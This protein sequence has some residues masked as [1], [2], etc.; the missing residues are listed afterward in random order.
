MISKIGIALLLASSVAAPAAWAGMSYSTTPP[1]QPQQAQQPAQTPPLTGDDALIQ[2]LMQQKLKQQ[3]AYDAINQAN[4]LS[5]Q[6]DPTKGADPNAKG[7][8]AE[9]QRLLSNPMVQSMGSVAQS[10]RVQALA[11]A[12]AS[13]PNRSMLLYVEIAVLVA[14]FIFRSWRQSMAGGWKGRLWVSVYSLVLLWVVAI[15][16]VPIIVLG[17]PWLQALNGAAG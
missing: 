3:Q 5:E 1:A 12:V 11:M 7:P 17:V 15:G 8:V 6:F 14:F 10:P 16:V 4:P 2:N 13:H 9:V